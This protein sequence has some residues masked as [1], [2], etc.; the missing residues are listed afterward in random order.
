MGKSIE[1]VN[2]NSIVCVDKIV[3]YKENKHLNQDIQ[4]KLVSLWNKYSGKQITGS[5][6]WIMRVYIFSVYKIVDNTEE[7]IKPRYSMQIGQSE[8][9]IQWT[10]YRECQ[11]DNKSFTYSVFTK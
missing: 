8:I 5:I 10:D 6:E 1:I 4:C 9:S 2:M 7:Q 3:D 11:L